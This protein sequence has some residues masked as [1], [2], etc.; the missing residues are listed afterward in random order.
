MLGVN[1]DRAWFARHVGIASVVAVLLLLVAMVGW[2][3]LYEI[4]EDTR[5]P[6]SLN[7]FVGAV[8]VGTL[9]LLSFPLGLVAWGLIELLAPEDV[10]P[11]FLL[12]VVG[13]I[14]D[15]WLYGYLVAFIREVIRIR[16]G[17]RAV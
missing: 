16:G 3:L 17:R 13:A 4:D 8:S 12:G 11:L 5:S 2:G 15:A 1:I 14:V 6:E 9:Y 7:T 10:L